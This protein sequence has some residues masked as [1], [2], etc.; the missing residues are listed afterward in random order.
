LP[1]DF[2]ASYRVHDGADPVSGVLIGLPLMSL[3]EVGRVWRGWADI[4]DDDCTVEDLSEDCQ[5][6]PLGAVK[7]LYAN[8]GWLPFAGDSQ[9]HVA[10]DFD[11][12]PEGRPGQVINCGRDDEMRHVIS[13]TF[14][15]FLTF[16]ARQF[17]L[18]RVGLGKQ[19]SSDAPRW[20]ALAG[21]KR[22]LLTGLR[23]LLGVQAE[24]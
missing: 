20:L 19:K 16:V 3:A 24:R 5:S 4:A 10:L 21:G 23:E 22:D 13:D 9:N 11:P 17:V 6:H 18:G 12:G 8:R 7:P 2:K 1:E 15:G 14:E